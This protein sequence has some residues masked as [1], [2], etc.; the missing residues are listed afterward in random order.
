MHSPKET[1]PG[2]WML[3]RS[4]WPCWQTCLVLDQ[5]W[6][7]DSWVGVTVAYRIRVSSPCWEPEGLAVT[8][9]ETCFEWVWGLLWF[10]FY[11]SSSPTRLLIKPYLCIWQISERTWLLTALSLTEHL[12][13]P[14]QIRQPRLSRYPNPNRC[15]QCPRAFLSEDYH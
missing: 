13:S 3:N 12:Q 1:G 9:Y 4:C 14:L 11:S 10:V 5:E 7:W 2:S 6:V 15:A 8:C